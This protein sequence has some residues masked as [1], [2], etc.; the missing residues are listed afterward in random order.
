M[1]GVLTTVHC[2]CSGQNAS[3]DGQLDENEYYDATFSAMTKTKTA[4]DRVENGKIR[5]RP[6]SGTRNVMSE[7]LPAGCCYHGSSLCF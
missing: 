3:D 6:D 1:T 2:G 4:I 5:V 7:F